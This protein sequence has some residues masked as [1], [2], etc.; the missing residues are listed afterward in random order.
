MKLKL[1][2]LSTLAPLIIILDQW[3]KH[4]ILENFRLGQTLEIIEGLFSFTYVRNPGAAFGMMNTWDPVYRIPF[5]IAVPIIALVAIVYVFKNLDN[6]DVLLASALTSVIGGAIGNLIDRVRFQYVVDFID[7]Y[8]KDIHFWTFN[9]AD[10]AISVGVCLLIIDLFKKEKQ[11]T[12]VS[13]A[14]TDR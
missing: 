14:D 2:I 9:I 1:I 8:H 11:K 6:R 4:Y 13:S 12:N 10:S 3:S 5:F 7:I